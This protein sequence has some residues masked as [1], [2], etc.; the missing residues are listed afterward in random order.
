MALAV[1]F[2]CVPD[3]RNDKMPD[4]AVYFVA[5]S[6]R[7]GVQTVAMYDVQT[8]A[9]NAP[10]HVYCAGFNEASPTVSAKVAEDYIEYYNKCYLVSAN[11]KKL[12]LLPASCWSLDKNSVTV[13]DRYATLNLQFNPQALFAFAEANDLTYTEM[14]SYVVPVKLESNGVDVAMY[15]DTASLGYV[16]VAPDMNKALIQMEV[17]KIDSRNY[18]V[19]V[20]VPFDNT[21]NI[22]YDL[23]LGKEF[24]AEP[25]TAY[26]NYYPGKMRFAEFPE[27]TI[28]KNSD[29]RSMAPGTS[30]VVYSIT[31][32]AKASGK[33]PVALTNVV[34]DGVEM[35]VVGGEALIDL[36]VVDLYSTSNG[37]AGNNYS[38]GFAE[39][40]IGLLGKTLTKYGLTEYG[41]DAEASF[42]FHPQSSCQYGGRDMGTGTLS[43]F[44]NNA[45]DWGTS[46]SGAG[47]TPNYADGAWNGGKSAYGYGTQDA[48]GV[49]WAL[50]DLGEVRPLSGIE[51]W[52]KCGNNAATRDLQFY[53]LD[54]CSYVRYN[55]I[56]EWED[57]D[58]TYLGKA[59][60]TDESK[61]NL[62]AT[63]WDTIQTQYLLVAF[64]ATNP[65]GYHCIEMV[66]YY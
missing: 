38:G 21:L 28:V 24:V 13:K 41:S 34:A 11:D 30:Q 59:S 63:T 44:S 65:T 1:L 3:S 46:W 49:M 29:V 9:I 53:A 33:Y 23:V 60:F 25:S 32:P 56:L 62:L 48:N 64:T 35:P 16:L 19:V 10:L 50:I 66:L 37:L 20:S 17:D 55:S 6:V 61:Y 15:K 22:S 2:S 45:D 57:K 4:A 40:E 12:N 36:G 26:G 7:N 47:A 39:D 51:W 18:D 58:V 52:R 14:K 27:G 54:K 8:E 5:N 43:V 31:F 42:I